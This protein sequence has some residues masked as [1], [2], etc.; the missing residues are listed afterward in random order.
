MLARTEQLELALDRLALLTAEAERHGSATGLAQAAHVRAHVEWLRGDAARAE[1]EARFAVDVARRGGFLGAA[2]IFVAGLLDALV[3]RDEARRGRRRARAR[4]LVG[5][6]SGG[7]WFSALVLSRGRLRL[8]QRRWDDAA[9]DFAEVQRANAADGI[10]SPFYSVGAQLALALAGEGREEEAR[11]ALAAETE[12]ARAW[13][14]PSAIATAL[15]VEGRLAGDTAGLPQLE[16]AVATLAD[17]PMRLDYAR[18]LV[19]LGAALRRANQRSKGRDRLRE[20]LELARAGGALAIAAR[21]HGELEASGERQR[22]LLAS[23]VESLTPSELR[24][25]ELAAEG[26]SNR[27]VAQ[28]LFLTVKTVESHLSNSYRKLDISSRSELPEAL[29]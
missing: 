23:G 6:A 26:L 10:S 20:A 2:P 4:R 25:A 7:Y 14:T 29:R 15:R 11:A 17:S 22:P 12:I 8:A 19:D 13:G 18:A 3:E 21:A 28:T 5:P 16:Q 1:T 9:A 24:V 27:D